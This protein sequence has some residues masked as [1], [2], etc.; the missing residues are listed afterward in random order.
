MA[1]FYRT[2]DR[3]VLLELLLIVFSIGTTDSE[4]E[5]VLSS[6]KPNSFMYSSLKKWISRKKF[7]KFL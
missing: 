6:N 7:K 5:G 4:M 3:T 1:K 2:E